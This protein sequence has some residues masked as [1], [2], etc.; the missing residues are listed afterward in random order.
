MNMK[1]FFYSYKTIRKTEDM[2][3]E[4]RQVIDAT[5]QY[6]R[7]ETMMY[8]L[9]LPATALEGVMNSV[10]RH[11]VKIAAQN[12]VTG[13]RGDVTGEISLD[14]LKALG[15]DMVRVGALDRRLALG[16]SGD[17]TVQNNLAA[18]DLG[19]KS[20]VCAGE[21]R[22]QRDDGQAGSVLATQIGPAFADIPE[23]AIY[24]TAV[25]YQPAWSLTENAGPEDLA[26][27]EGQIGTIR[28]TLEKVQ[29]GLPEPLPVIYGGRLAGDDAL[30]LLR[31][32]TLDGLFVEDDVWDVKSFIRIITETMQ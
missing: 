21:T 10:D 3:A 1:F 29:P 15:V 6:D 5:K 7:S 32:D 30:R 27:L 17:L 11:F 12:A 8:F 9:L 13:G 31:D 2:A 20:L 4:V 19:L 16:E 18:L 25:M 28:A 24:R 14:R 26:Y 22:E 23:S